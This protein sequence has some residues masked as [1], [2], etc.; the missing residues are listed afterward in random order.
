MKI[1]VNLSLS[2]TKTTIAAFIAVCSF[3]FGADAADLPTSHKLVH[4]IYKQ[5]VDIDTT[6]STGDTTKAAEALAQ[7]F[8]SG[9]FSASDVE[10]IGPSARN[11]NFVVHYRGSGAKPPIALLAHLDVVEAKRSDWTFDPFKLTETNGYF[12][13]RGSSDDKDGAAQLAAAL[14][15]LRQEN[16]RPNRDIYLALTSGEEGGSAYNGAQWLLT[17]HHAIAKAR[18]CLNADAGGPEK[19]RGKDLMFAAQA[20]EKVYQ[21]YRLEVKG[22]GGHSS[23]PT[24]E[25]PIYR[26][27]AGLLRLQQFEFPPHLDE[28]TRGYFAAMSKLQTGQIA[29]DM[30]AILKT[31]SDPDALKRLSADPVYNA[32]LRTTAVATMLEAGHAENALPQTARATINCRMLPSESIDDL[33]KTLRRVL[34][35]DQITVKPIKPPELGPPSPLTP[36]VMSAIQRAKEAVWPGLP[37]VPVMLAGAT[38]GLYFRLQ[39]IPTYGISGTSSDLDDVRAHGKDERVGV[40]DFYRGA[41]FEYQL[42][43]AICSDTK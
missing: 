27:A 17:N 20:A 31:P 11:K 26:L 7:R 42:V 40:E 34:A 38:D 12:Y 14:L 22:R 5:L 43:K 13:G 19:R 18:F 37:I 2:K 39:G 3:C 1:R 10:V 35:D 9:G 8:Q 32:Q 23:L 29:A 4:D 41:E 24:K 33:E 36:E 21:S 25:N 16:F 28:I 6:H 15:R 30:Q